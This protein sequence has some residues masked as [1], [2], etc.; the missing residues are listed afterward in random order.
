MKRKAF[1]SHGLYMTYNIEQGTITLGLVAGIP[2]CIENDRDGTRMTLPGNLLKELI[3]LA[4][5]LQR[6]LPRS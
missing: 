1:G 3:T 4:Q 6:P 5:E 2:C